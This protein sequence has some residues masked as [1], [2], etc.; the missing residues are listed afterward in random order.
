MPF[1]SNPMNVCLLGCLLPPLWKRGAD[2]LKRVEE[3]L[4]AGVAK[5]RT[6][7]GVFAATGLSSLSRTTGCR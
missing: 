4:R 1:A 2:N 7:S 5:R 6:D 3:V